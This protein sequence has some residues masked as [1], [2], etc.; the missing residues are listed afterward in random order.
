MDLLNS[1]D[2]SGAGINSADCDNDDAGPGFHNLIGPVSQSNDANGE[3][4]ITLLL[5]NLT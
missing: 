5:L 3:Q 4:V 2:E 1:C